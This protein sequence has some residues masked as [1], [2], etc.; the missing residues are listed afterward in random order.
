[1]AG[2]YCII[3]DDTAREELKALFGRNAFLIGRRC[4][5]AFSEE[6]NC[7]TFVKEPAQIVAH[8]EAFGLPPDLV[9]GGLADLAALA[10]CWKRQGALSAA[11]PALIV[12]PMEDDFKPNG[13]NIVA[14]IRAPS[15]RSLRLW[16][17]L[18]KTLSYLKNEGATLPYTPLLFGQAV[19]RTPLP[20]L[21][22]RI[23]RREAANGFDAIADGLIPVASIC[24]PR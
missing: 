7:V 1:M 3:G 22:G 12:A 6:L 15:L 21:P 4:D 13:L 16:G 20:S 10:D 23:E 5:E 24:A 8:A 11:C 19:K 14:G 2:V 18:S 9:V 17:H